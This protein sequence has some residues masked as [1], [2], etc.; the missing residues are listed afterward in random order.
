MQCIHLGDCKSKVWAAKS[1]IQHPGQALSDDQPL[2]AVLFSCGI[3]TL[4]CGYSDILLKRLLHVFLNIPD[5]H[6]MGTPPEML[7]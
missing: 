2:F 1:P 7:Q 6:V 3:M 4:L 5:L